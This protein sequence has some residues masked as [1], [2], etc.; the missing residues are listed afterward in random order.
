MLN[1]PSAGFSISYVAFCFRVIFAFW[2]PGDFFVLREKEIT[3][4]SHREQTDL[5]DVFVAILSLSLNTHSLIL[6]AYKTI[7]H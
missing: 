1:E 7:V 4:Q 3:R 2:F 6:I 5:I